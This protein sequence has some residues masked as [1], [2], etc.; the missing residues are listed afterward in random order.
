MSSSFF[1]TLSAGI[2]NPVT[3]SSIDNDIRLGLGRADIAKEFYSAENISRRVL[4]TGT[5]ANEDEEP[6]KNKKVDYWAASAA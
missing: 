6:A 2:K 3:L 5:I 4:D 1:V